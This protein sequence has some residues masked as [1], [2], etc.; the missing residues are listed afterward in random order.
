MHACMHPSMHACMHAYIH[1]CMH[2]CMHACIHPCMHASMHACIHACMKYVCICIYLYMHM[3][4]QTHMYIYAYDRQLHLFT[5]VVVDLEPGINST[6]RRKMAERTETGQPCGVVLYAASWSKSPLQVFCAQLF[7]GWGGWGRKRQWGQRG[8]TWGSTGVWS[9]AQKNCN[10]AVQMGHSSISWV[11]Y[12]FM[13]L[14]H[15]EYDL[16]MMI[17]TWFNDMGIMPSCLHKA[18]IG[19][20]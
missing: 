17:K 1:P 11:S 2:A 9:W 19:S 15:E 14:F 20:R 7:P 10:I 12:L 3:Y 18:R 5:Q 16:N 4:T 13:A 8:R 6:R